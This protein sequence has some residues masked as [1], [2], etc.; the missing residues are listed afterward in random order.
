MGERIGVEIREK[1][2]KKKIDRGFVWIRE[3]SGLN[4]EYDLM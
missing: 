1:R 3:E 4:G 2:K